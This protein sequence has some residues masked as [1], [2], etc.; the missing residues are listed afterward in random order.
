MTD[1][2]YTDHVIHQALSMY[3]LGASPEAIKAAFTESKSYQRPALPV[4]E[5]VV[6]AL[7]DESKFKDCV[8]KEEHYP[9]FLAYFQREIEAK[10]V[11]AVVNKHLFAEDEHAD[12][13][14]VRSFSGTF[15]LPWP[16]SPLLIA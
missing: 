4:D 7:S 12:D 8:E 5:N 3:A 14:L 2:G 13:L 1:R 9:N 10:G 15:P 16:L 11:G 6:K